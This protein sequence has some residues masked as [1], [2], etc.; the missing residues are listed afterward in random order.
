MYVDSLIDWDWHITVYHCS[1]LY[2]LFSPHWLP[3]N[4]CLKLDCYKKETYLKTIYSLIALAKG[5][6]TNYGEGG[7][8]NGRGGGKWSL[9]PTKGGGGAENVLAMLKGGTKSFEVG[10]TRELEVW[11][12]VMGGGA[13]KV[14]IIEGGGAQKVL[15][16]FPNSDFPIL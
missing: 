13:Q 5:L 10:L 3:G 11:A 12:I 1:S 15:P 6:V 7:L 2:S 9:T 14:F 16:C 4:T 8:Q